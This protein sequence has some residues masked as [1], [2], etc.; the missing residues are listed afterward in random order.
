MYWI[1]FL[2]CTLLS[3]WMLFCIINATTVLLFSVLL[4]MF[5]LRVFL[6]WPILVLGLPETTEYTK[7]CSRNMFFLFL[8]HHL[9]T[10]QIHLSN[11][12][13]GIRAWLPDWELL[14]VS[15]TRPK[16]SLI[17]SA[18]TEANIDNHLVNSETLQPERYPR[19]EA[20][21]ITKHDIVFVKDTDFF[22][23]YEVWG[24]NVHASDEAKK[25]TENKS[26][27]LVDPWK[28]GEPV[29]SLIH[30]T[31]YHNLI[32]SLIEFQLL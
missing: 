17:K 1:A 10:R 11:L 4:W 13:R 27:F 5:D 3:S 20:V 15:Q 8:H 9:E 12:C 6:H 21:Y 18:A 26:T 2:R 7:E 23:D 22:I 31:N 32:L 30:K 24:F 16:P 25:T 19:R 29:P 28:S 14:I